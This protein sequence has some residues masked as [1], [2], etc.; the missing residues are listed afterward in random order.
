MGDAHETLLDEF[1]L[2]GREVN[3]SGVGVLEV[4][5]VGW[6]VH[7]GFLEG[8]DPTPVDVAG[9]GRFEVGILFVSHEGLVLDGFSLWR[10]ERFEKVWLGPG[11]FENR[12]FEDCWFILGSRRW[13]LISERSVLGEPLLDERR[14]GR[15]LAGSEGLDGGVGSSSKADALAFHG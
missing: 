13:Q 10:I 9:L 14:R 8:Y 12:R 1:V 4:V 5:D 15:T 7:G 11:G 6:V 2:A 3:T